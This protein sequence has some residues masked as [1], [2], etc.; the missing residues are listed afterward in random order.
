MSV[1][2]ALQPRTL[3][4]S[5]SRRSQSSPAPR[6][7]LTRRG[8]L[9]LV[10]LPLMVAAA[11]LMLLAGAFTAPAKAAGTLS[12]P[13]TVKITVGAGQTLW[14][15]ATLVAPERHPQEVIA[16]IAQLNSLEG[17]VVHAGQQVFVPFSR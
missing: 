12:A 11:A 4:P 10:V 8:R 6:L 15:I 14:D 7:R 2:L 1:Q 17:S 3:G 16:E 13:E 5:L 9:V